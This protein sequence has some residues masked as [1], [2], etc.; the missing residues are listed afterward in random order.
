M[1]G[2]TIVLTTISVLR[3]FGL[4]SLQDLAKLGASNL[5][6]TDARKRKENADE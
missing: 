6:K 4:E 1:S 5:C 3:L 2:V